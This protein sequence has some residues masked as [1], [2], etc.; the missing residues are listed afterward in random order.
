MNE[1][2]TALL[3]NGS[4][5]LNVTLNSSTNWTQFITTLVIA[6]ITSFGIFLF[7]YFPK[8]F[9]FF[10]INSGLRKLSKLTNT[11]IVMI[12]HTEHGFFSQ[13]MIDQNTLIN[14]S[15]VMTKM[16]GLD[17]DL[18]LHTPG[19]EIF[20]SIA[21]SR[22]IK[23]Y[24]GKI[25]AIIPLYSMSGGSLLALSCKELLMT[26]N[27]SLGC[28]DPQLGNFLRYGSAKGWNEIVKF[29]GKKAEDQSISFAMMGKQYTKSIRNHLRNIIDFN[30][31]HPQKDRLIN[32]LTSGDV[33]H[34]YPLTVI[35]LNKF[36]IQPHVLH[37]QRYIKL[38]IKVI[39]SDGKE[40][41]SYYKKGNHFW[42]R[43]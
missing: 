7:I 41:V 15:K 26:S 32:F 28:I 18:I 20:S 31:N 3:I 39:G 38:L 5:P 21:I 42:N 14:L 13:S 25:R 17:F 19:G 23:Q 10:S 1:A 24:P 29:K 40:G 33:E 11:N 43:E 9:G 30:L 16:N 2:I 36:G 12:K 22:L 35:D 8:I 37:N 34:A 4:I 27:A 6:L